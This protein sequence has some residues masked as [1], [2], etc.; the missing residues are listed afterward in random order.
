MVCKQ[1][2]F[3]EIG[4]FLA[5]KCCNFSVKLM[6]FAGAT[7]LTRG[8]TKGI[9]KIWLDDVEC[10][11]SEAKLV[12]CNARVIG[13]HDCTHIEDAGVSCPGRL[14]VYIMMLLLNLLLR[15]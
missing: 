12:D 13:E 8:F 14:C 15:V 10:S 2:G 11:G 1:A 6:V 7:A 9:G 3:S 5:I 4:R